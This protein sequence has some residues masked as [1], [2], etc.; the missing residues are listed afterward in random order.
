MAVFTH[1]LG[2]TYHTD[3]G[4]I[5]TTT[6]VYTGDAENDL[7]E[8]V[9]ASTTNKQY[10]MAIDVS[11]I[12]SMVIF[13]NGALT[14]KTNSTSSPIDTVVLVANKVVVWNTDSVMANPLTAD[15]TTLY[16]TNAAV[17]PVTLKIRILEAVGV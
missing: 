10:L 8:V 4:T 15:V 1:T 6:D 14:L 11:K 2:T 7:E 17:T 13:A 3:A 16:A 5:A 12:V 9:P